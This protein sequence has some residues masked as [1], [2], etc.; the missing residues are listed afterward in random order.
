MRGSER[1]HVDHG[2]R[3]GI[4]TRCARRDLCAS[5]AEVNFR[6]G[7]YAHSAECTMGRIAVR[8]AQERNHIAAAGV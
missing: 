5:P 7:A 6:I 4:G 2:G 3:R 8:P 1:K